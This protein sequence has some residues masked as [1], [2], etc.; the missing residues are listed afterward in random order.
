M[1]AGSTVWFLAYVL[2][3]IGQV[4]LDLWPLGALITAIFWGLL[5][6]I[7]AGLAG[8]WLYQ[9]QDQAA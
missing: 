6:M 2:P 9:E 5:E 4:T 3:T 1:C 7:V 8:G